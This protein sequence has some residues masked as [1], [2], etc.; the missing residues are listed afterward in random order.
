MEYTTHLVLQSR[1]TRLSVLTCASLLPNLTGLQPSMAL[2]MNRLR[3]GA[4]RRSR[5]KVCT[6]DHN[7]LAGFWIDRFPLH[8]PLLGESRLVSVPPL[9]N[10]LKFSGCPYLRSAWSYKWNTFDQ[11]SPRV[12]YQSVRDQPKLRS[13][14]SFEVALER[15]NH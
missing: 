9:N 6:A 5:G 13:W 3:M 15:P 1:A 2:C 8:S 12:R 14:V 10:M 4:I 11:G 7:S